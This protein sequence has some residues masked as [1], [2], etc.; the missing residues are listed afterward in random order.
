MANLQI[1]TAPHPLLRAKTEPVETIDDELRRLMDDMLE[2]MY[3]AP[4]VGLAAPQ[5]GVTK[6]VI[7]VDVSRDDEERR[8]MRLI[9]PEVVWRSAADEIAE[10]GCLS[11]PDQFAE[12]RRASQVKVRYRDETGQEQEISG[13]GILARCLQHEIDH[14]NGVLFIDHLTP[15]KR[16]MIIRK[17]RKSQ[18]LRA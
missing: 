14:L 6:R 2:T 18:R 1:L 8:P 12:V 16:N 9:N 15:L 10:E 11:L 3:A 13:D 4:G 7:V 17:L 5:I